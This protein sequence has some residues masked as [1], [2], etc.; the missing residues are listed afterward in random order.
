M[1][2]KLKPS[3]SHL[4]VT[5]LNPRHCIKLNYN[6]LMEVIQALRKFNRGCT[7][8]R[9]KTLVIQKMIAIQNYIDLGDSL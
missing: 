9:I 1:I 5:E 8:G 4:T 2:K 3:G 7:D 6:R